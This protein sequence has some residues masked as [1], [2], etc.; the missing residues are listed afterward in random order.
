MA[1]DFGMIKLLHAGV[2][3]HGCPVN[4]YISSLRILLGKG[5][6]GEHSKRFELISIFWFIINRKPS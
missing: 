1:V 6:G 4:I 3:N 2:I 5:S